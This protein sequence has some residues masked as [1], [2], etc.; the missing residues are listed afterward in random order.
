MWKRVVNLSKKV[1]IRNFNSM[2]EKG[3]LL[4]L[5][6][7]AIRSGVLVELALKVSD[8]VQSPILAKTLLVVVNAHSITYS[9]R[10]FQEV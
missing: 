6:L 4:V 5:K 9:P 2:L 10:L 3:G 1:R 7:K 8:G